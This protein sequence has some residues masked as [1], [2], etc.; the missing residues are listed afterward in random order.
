MSKKEDKTKNYFGKFID[1]QVQ[2]ELVTKERRRQRIIPD[3]L[4]V[5]RT[6]LRRYRE[7]ITHLIR[8]NKKNG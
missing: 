5:K 6:L 2:R 4:D 3:D 8:R 7:N 1:D